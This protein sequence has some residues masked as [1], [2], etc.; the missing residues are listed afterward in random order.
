MKGPRIFV[1]EISECFWC[2]TIPTIRVN[3]LVTNF[4]EN[5]KILYDFFFWE[6]E[7]NYTKLGIGSK[8]RP[9]PGSEKSL[10][11]WITD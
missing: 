10:S 6:G 3:F 2:S 4:F 9:T 7:R 5:F 1:V 11:R 8:F